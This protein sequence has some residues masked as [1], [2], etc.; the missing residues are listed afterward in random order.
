V[1][2]TANRTPRTTLDVFARSITFKV[3][4]PRASSPTAAFLRKGPHNVGEKPISIL[5]SVQP[6]SAIG[7]LLR[8]GAFS[9]S[10]WA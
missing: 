3:E 4:K 1:N 2:G 9:V 5:A 8:H 7:R 6:L 10:S